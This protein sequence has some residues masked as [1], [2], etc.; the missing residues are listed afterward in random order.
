VTDAPADRAR[1]ARCDDTRSARGGDTPSAPIIR[2]AGL[3]KRFGD[4]TAVDDLDFE[5]APGSLFA[6][7]GANGS[8]KSTTIRMLIGLLTPTA[9]TIEVDGVDVIERPRRVRDHIG[10]MGQKVSLYQGLSLREN[11]EFYAGLYGMAGAPLEQRWEELRE[12]FDL[13]AVEH[14]KASDLPAGVRQRAGLAL[15][16]LH[17]PRVLFLDEPTAGVDL[18]NRLLF[19]DRIREEAAAG[20]TVFV[21]THFLEEVEYCDWACFI[22]AGRL[23][24]NAE[25]DE[26]RRRFS[27]GYRVTVALPPAARSAARADLAAAGATVREDGDG[28]VAEAPALSPALLREAE[29]L[30]DADPDARVTIVRPE[31]TDVFRRLMLAAKRGEGDAGATSRAIVASPQSARPTVAPAPTPR[32]RRAETSTRLRARA[33]RLRALL[34]RETRATLRDPFTVTILIAVPLAALLAFGLTLSTEVKHLR[35]GLHDASDTAASRRLT[36]ELAANGTFA[37]RRYATREAIQRALVSGDVSVAVVVPPDFDRR[38]GAR[39]PGD[40]TPELQVLY[41]GGETVVAGNAEGF[42]QALLAATGL[43]LTAPPPRSDPTR[44]PPSGGVATVTRALF[45]PTLDGTPFMVAG[46]YGFVLTFLTTLI[47]AVSVVNERLG[48]TFDQLQVTPATS[49]EIVLGKILPLG[50]VFAGDVVLMLLMAGFVL[51]VWPSGNPLF[52][53]VATASY[54]V[55]S[56]STGLILSATSATAAEAVQKTVLFS[57]PLIYLGGFIFPVGNMPI[58]FRWISEMLPATHYIRIARA[59]YLRGAGPVQLLPELALLALFGA[60]L[61]SIAFRTVESRA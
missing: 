38:L 22:D 7:L 59:I 24:A 46:T 50:A 10:Y 44:G 39:A 18:H 52:F 40:P 34:V 28:L 54:V 2:A 31:M 57:I 8:G 35:L 37:I 42:L 36:A 43:A 27:D 11:L 6:F 48:G 14:E 30:A 61:M 3:T 49:A 20:V 16:T 4:F 17:R 56:L 19:W 21:T 15:S 29:R 58:G 32:E 41:D 25:P 9:G 53:V 47:T 60:V 33:R 23:I 26:I 45:N 55:V 51:G 12:R 1:S 13:G 5:V